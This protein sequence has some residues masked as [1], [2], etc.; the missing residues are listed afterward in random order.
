MYLP[1]GCNNK[2]LIKEFLTKN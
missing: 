1:K 2:K